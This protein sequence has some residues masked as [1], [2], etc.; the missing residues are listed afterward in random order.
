MLATCKAWRAI[1]SADAFWRELCLAQYPRVKQI[2]EQMPP[3]H[4]AWRQL[5]RR[6]RRAEKAQRSI[7]LAYRGD[8]GLQRPHSEYVYTVEVYNDRGPR[9][10]SRPPLLSTSGRLEDCFDCLQLWKDGDE[11]SWSESLVRSRRESDYDRERWRTSPGGRI[12]EGLRVMCFVTRPDHAS[13]CLY[14]GLLERSDVYGTLESVLDELEHGG[15]DLFELSFAEAPL[16][17]AG[18]V[19]Y[20]PAHLATAKVQLTLRLRSE[21]FHYLERDPKYDPARG[22]L[23]NRP[24][25]G[26]LEIRYLDGNGD[27]TNDTHI[28]YVCEYLESFAPF[29]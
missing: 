9:W 6:Q 10:A 18:A 2:L 21:G 1:C 26:E 25:V 24:G 29:D 4:P 23:G 19:A 8:V 14:D 13:F 3:P 7:W 22:K 27:A 16:P 12:A 11:P 20:A 5:Y 17:R 15:D 28:A